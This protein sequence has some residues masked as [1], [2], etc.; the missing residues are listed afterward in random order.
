MS[1]YRLLSPLSVCPTWNSP[2]LGMIITGVALS[3]SFRM[4]TSRSRALSDTM[5][6]S[7]CCCRSVECSATSCA[8]QRRK[9]P[10]CCSSRSSSD[11]Q[12]MSALCFAV[13]A[14]SPIIAASPS[15][16]WMPTVSTPGV[17]S[18]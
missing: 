15:R 13:S 8:A 18:R 2:P 14:L 12:A 17:R 3:F 1:L 6:Y 4:S 9:L 7:V 10:A 11:C 16:I 5:K